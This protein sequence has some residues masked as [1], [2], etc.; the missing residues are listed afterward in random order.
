MPSLC[1]TGRSATAARPSRT[2]PTSS[3][4]RSPWRTAAPTRPS[5]CAAWYDELVGSGAADQDSILERY[6]FELAWTQYRR[7]SLGTTV[8]PVSAMGAMDPANERGREL[9]A[10]MAVRSFSAAL[11]LDAAE[12]LPR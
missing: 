9:V 10:P 1:S 5:W 8:Y 6:P 4:S 2:S 11:D 12:L 3:A 7:A